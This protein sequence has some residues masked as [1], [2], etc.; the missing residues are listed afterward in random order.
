MCL[1]TSIGVTVRVAERLI[2]SV[3]SG[4]NVRMGVG[5]S[6]GASVSAGVRESAISEFG[7]TSML[8]RFLWHLGGVSGHNITM[9]EQ[10]SDKQ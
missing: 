2:I 1:S 5:I 4:V 10:V 8:T 9:E 7:L 3:S 6:V